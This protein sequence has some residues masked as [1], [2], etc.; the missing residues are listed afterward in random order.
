MV[1]R[2]IGTAAEERMMRIPVVRTNSIRV[3][4]AVLPQRAPR[5][6]AAENEMGRRKCTGLFLLNSNSTFA[7]D[8]LDRPLLG[9]LRVHLHDRQLR[10]AWSNAFDH[11]A[12]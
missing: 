7:G 3:N 6:F 9:I 12:N 8:H 1:T 5:G 2:N 10:T 11:D 4:P